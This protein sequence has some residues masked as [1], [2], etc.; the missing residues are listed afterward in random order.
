MEKKY[1]YL[2]FT[3]AK[4]PI[5]YTE[6]K[7]NSVYD[8]FAFITEDENKI[9][10][11]ILKNKD[12]ESEGLEWFWIVCKTKTEGDIFSSPDEDLNYIYKMYDINGNILEEQLF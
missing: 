2:L 12:A 9:V 7:E 6:D 8:S 10:P 5:N 1:V 11:Y 4:L 3:R